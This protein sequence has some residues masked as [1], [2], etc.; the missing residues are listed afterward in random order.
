VLIILLVLL[1][2]IIWS[3]VILQQIPLVEEVTLDQVDVGGTETVEEI[4][5]HVEDRGINPI[6]T[7]LLHDVDIAGSVTFDDLVTQL[8]DDVRTI[9]V[10]LPG[11]GLTTRF[12][13]TGVEHTVGRMAER[14]IS[15][16]EARTAGPAVLVGVGLGGEVAAEVAVLRPELVAGLLMID[17]DFYGGGGWVQTGEGLPWMGVAFTYAFETSGAFGDDAFA[18]HCA[19]GGWCPSLAQV[20]ARSLAA[21]IV[22]TTESLHAFRTTP[23][24]SN[25]PSLLGDITAP[26]I[27][28]WS[29]KGVVPQSSVDRVDA[30][31][32]DV[33]IERIDVFQA[34]LEEPGRVAELVR[35]LLP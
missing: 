17:V 1:G 8:G 10:D 29:E 23:P 4:R 24:A 12:P 6:P 21:S 32:A 20:A 22:D 15:I 14:I 3:A 30:A 18:P 34:L 26:T 33:Q 2:S 25:V 13:E 28:V 11:F 9:A 5:F 31:M 27:Y 35:S 19:D 7:F 16:I